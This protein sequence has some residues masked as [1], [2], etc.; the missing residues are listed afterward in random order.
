MNETCQACMSEETE[1]LQG[2]TGYAVDP[3]ANARGS[4]FAPGVPPSYAN[5]PAIGPMPGIQFVG[6]PAGQVAVPVV[7][8]DRHVPVVVGYMDHIPVV[9]AGYSV[10]L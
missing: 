4:L 1:V 10:G 8:D 5:I 2:A 6:E 9:V 3:G 7:A